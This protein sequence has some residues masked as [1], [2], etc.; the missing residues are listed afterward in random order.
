MLYKIHELQYQ[1]AVLRN[2]NAN[3]EKTENNNDYHRT[4]GSSGIKMEKDRGIL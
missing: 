1:E 3:V 2:V 4:V